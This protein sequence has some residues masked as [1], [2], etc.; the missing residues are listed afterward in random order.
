[1]LTKMKIYM[2][3]RR[4]MVKIKAHSV[5]EWMTRW[6]RHTLTNFA[7]VANDGIVAQNQKIMAGFLEKAG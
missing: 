1:M 7:N 3:F 5:N 6:T 2:V 4:H